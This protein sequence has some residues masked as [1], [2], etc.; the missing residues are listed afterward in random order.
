[1]AP[2]SQHPVPLLPNVPLVIGRSSAPWLSN[3]HISRSQAV[4]LWRIMPNGES[5]IHMVNVR[6]PCLPPSTQEMHTCASVPP[7]LVRVDER[8]CVCVSVCVCIHL[9]TLSLRVCVRVRGTC[10]RGRTRAG[11]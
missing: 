5:V 7:P 8:V 2:L 4:F 11:C 3:L 10:R 1:M 9:C 6:F